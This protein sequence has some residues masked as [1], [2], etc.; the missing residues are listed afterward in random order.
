MAGRF[1]EFLLRGRINGTTYFVYGVVLL[2]LKFAIDQ[3]F[4]AAALFGRPWGV[5]QYL[6]PMSL[7]MYSRLFNP[8]T[9]TPRELL[10]YGMLVLGALPFIYI[11]VILTLARLRDCGGS[12]GWLLLF[13]V[14]VANLLLFLILSIASSRPSADAKPAA[15]PSPTRESP[16]E[17]RPE[18][19]ANGQPANLTYASLPDE[20][21][22][23]RL[24]ALLPADRAA[25]FALAAIVPV[26]FAMSAIMLSTV[27]LKQYGTGIFIG[28]P[29]AVGLSSALL[30]AVRQ[31]RRIGDCF[32]ASLASL[33]LLSFVLFSFAIE[34]LVCLLM[35]MPLA[36]C[37]AFF[38]TIIGVAIARALGVPAAG[39]ALLLVAATVPLQMGLDHF[40]EPAASLVAV[41]TSLRV[42]APPQR[43]WRHVIEFP[44]L[45]A[46]N[47]W[48]FRA[49]IAY[50]RCARIEGQGVGA[51]R[52]CVFSTGE[53][54]EPI[55]TWDEPHL[56]AFSVVS[57]APPMR[58][59]SIYD[60]VEPPHLDGFLQSQR[61]EFQ[62]IASPDGRTTELIG[63][64]W[65][66]NRMWPAAYWQFWSDH[67]IHRIHHRVLE[68]VRQLSEPAE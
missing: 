60:G 64:T 41:R 17:P 27:L 40:A 23:S 59:W 28:V 57:Q 31:P 56:L 53:F 52:H 38:G 49:G 25:H 4:I 19:A 39:S 61:G 29:F 34:G 43:V 16:P 6:A 58:E 62:L 50:P 42:N 45:A 47:E 68:H 65:Y 5:W 33:M 11:G 14:P 36:M 37:M 35:A 63:T 46:P 7:P 3:Q 48:L 22:G 8:G 30:V 13:F 51:T 66:T 67:I 12:A 26:P 15:A 10:F 20:T 1:Y 44:P 32:G 54:V 24:A 21:P 2:L 55:T 18:P 9:T